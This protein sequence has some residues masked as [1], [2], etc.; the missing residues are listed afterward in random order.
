MNSHN[1]IFIFKAENAA[2]TSA[3]FSSFESMCDWIQKYYLSGMV[4]E[5]PLDVSSYDWAVENGYFARKSPID[6]A[7]IFIASFV[8]AYQKQWHFKHG[9]ILEEITEENQQ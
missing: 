1:S 5:Y 3:V 7:P 9:E 6:S 4:I 8:S 2:L